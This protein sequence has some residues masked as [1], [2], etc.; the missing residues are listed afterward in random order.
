MWT[1][2]LAM[3][4][5]RVTTRTTL[6]LASL[7]QVGGPRVRW[8]LRC[9]NT[10]EAVDVSRRRRRRRRRRSRARAR[11]EGYIRGH[12]MLCVRVDRV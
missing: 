1:T 9:E 10:G 4:I 2:S 8:K 5:F 6:P 7:R 12:C 3:A 11:V